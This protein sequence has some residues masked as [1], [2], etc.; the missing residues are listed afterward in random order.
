MSEVVREFLDRLER[1]EGSAEDRAL[2]D[3]LAWWASGWKARGASAPVGIVFPE[4]LVPGEEVVPAASRSESVLAEL[5]EIYGSAKNGEAEDLPV[6][7]VPWSAGRGDSDVEEWPSRLKSALFAVFLADEPPAEVVAS[8]DA[9]AKWNKPGTVSQPDLDFAEMLRR[10][11]GGEWVEVRVEGMTKTQVYW[12]AQKIT[13]SGKAYRPPGSF[14]ARLVQRGNEVRLFALAVK[15]A[16]D[17][18][19]PVDPAPAWSSVEELVGSEQTI[20]AE[21]LVAAPAARARTDSR[22]RPYKGMSEASRRAALKAPTTGGRGD[23][24]AGAGGGAGWSSV[25]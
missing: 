6:G 17:E 9:P 25:R 16:S 3:S 12:L 1:G 2:A 21:K 20:S 8:V 11:Y 4:R 5:R 19:V 24:S 7:P 10:D 15:Q 13:G 22:G 14:E 23:R 18:S